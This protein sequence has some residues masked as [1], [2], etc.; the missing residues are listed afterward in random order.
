MKIIGPGRRL[1]KKGLSVRV[2]GGGQAGV[3][4]SGFKTLRIWTLG[5]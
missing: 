3:A 2:L 4:V 5:P 1:K